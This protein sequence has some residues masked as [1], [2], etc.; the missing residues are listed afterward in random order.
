MSLPLQRLPGPASR[1]LNLFLVSVLGLFVELMLIRWIATEFRIFAYLQNTVLVVCFLGLGMGCWTCR[2]PIIF[3]QALGPLLALVAILSIPAVR[4]RIAED[5]ERLSLIHLIWGYVVT[6]DVWQGYLAIALALVQTLVL[7]LL[8][9]ASFVPLGRLLGRLLDDHPRPIWA[10]SVNIAGSLAGIMLYALLCATSMSPLVWCAVAALLMLPYSEQPYWKSLGLLTL[11]VGLS[12]WSVTHP[13]TRTARPSGVTETYLGCWW[14]P[15]QKL[16]LV[17]EARTL[18]EGERAILTLY[19]NNCPYM[20]LMDLRTSETDRF[21]QLFPPALR[22]LSQY[23]LPTKF[24]PSPRRMLIIGS[25]GGN[26]VAG[27]L[28]GGAEAI[29]AVE[30][31]PTIIDVGRRFHPEQPYSSPRVTVVNNDARAYFANTQER[32]D[33]I[34]FGLLDSHTT[35]AMTNARLDHYVYTQESFEQARRLLS[36]GGVIVLSFE[37]QK[38]FIADRMARAL[39]AVFGQEPLHFRVPPSEYGYG[40]YFFV[41]GDLENVRRRIATEPALAAAVAGWQQA[42]L[43]LAGTTVIA[44]DDWPYIYLETTSVPPLYWLLGV[45]LLVLFLLANLMLGTRELLAGWRV[46]HL[47]FFF[48]GAAFMLLE[49]QNISKAAVVLGNTW[50]VNAVIIASIMVVILLAN[51]LAAALPRLPLSL[52]YACLIGSAVGL[53]FVDLAWFAPLPYFARA[54]VVGLLTSL[55]MLF[56]GIVFIRS[57]ATTPGKDAALGANLFGAL[58]GGLLQSLTFVTGIKALLL[59]VAALYAAAWL[60]K[61]RPA[62]AAAVSSLQ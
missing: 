4:L 29:T 61:P 43:Q 7:M 11:L 36:P 14:S 34:V 41:V 3:R 48:L 22:G 27:G 37:A 60:S 1:S 52:A 35:T 2:R 59:V 19:V 13:D 47:H 10:Y 57:F 15:Y 28:R 39:R 9:W 44:T 21:P 24:Q 45:T 23:D 31:D 20:V 38:P 18:P 33:L 55:P 26:D 50:D 54:L 32:F 53:Y 40:G 42:G 6:T 5:T 46:T 62:T 51:L 25:G 56:S 8:I 58:V 12:G 49:V 17:K 16:M 30:I